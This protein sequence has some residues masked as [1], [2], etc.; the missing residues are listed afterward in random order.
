M[1]GPLRAQQTQEEDTTPSMEAEEDESVESQ[2]AG[3]VL[4]ETEGAEVVS[5][6]SA[7]ASKEKKRG[8]DESLK[9][10][11]F[12]KEHSNWKVQT[13]ANKLSVFVGEPVQDS[14]SLLNPSPPFFFKVVV[15][16]WNSASRR[17]YSDFEWV[18]TVLE[19]R[20]VGMVAPGLPEK[21]IIKSE[22]SLRNRQ[23]G[24]ARFA[25]RLL[26]NPYFRTD[27]V[28]LSFL[29]IEDSHEW[30]VFK[31]SVTALKPGSSMDK[32]SNDDNNGRRRWMEAMNAYQI[33]GNYK[34]ILA[35]AKT[36]L[37]KLEDVF[38]GM[39]QAF[40]KLVA[41]TD[42]QASALENLNSHFPSKE[43]HR[44]NETG[45]DGEL[46][47]LQGRFSRWATVTSCLP[48]FIDSELFQ[49]ATQE[50]NDVQEVQRLIAKVDT[51]DANIFRLEQVLSK[52]SA[53]RQNFERAGRFDKV[54][55]TS[56]KIATVE[57]KR[58]NLIVEKEQ[59]I[60]GILLT[61][62]DMFVEL[63]TMRLKS[64]QSEFAKVYLEFLDQEKEVW[65]TF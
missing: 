46:E 21:H 38:N 43:V 39:T 40:Q 51:L 15:E 13:V 5:S 55:K 48:T 41:S 35:N 8:E 42:A 33:P 63:K 2:T 7:D 57:L 61:E 62:L 25:E 44:A 26:E 11:E 1:E 17:R 14:R 24:L 18:R 28:V 20:Y 37:I 52:C 27:S 3:D 30:D 65:S 50:L 53:E 58:K 45:L 54:G 49:T 4:H 9:L 60:K 12:W 47:Q 32:N 64:M 31:R 19:R 36:L 22:E 6:E 34:G 59:I 29:K 10:N 23:R 16:E 56:E